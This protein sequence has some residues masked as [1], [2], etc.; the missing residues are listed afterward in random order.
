MSND[1]ITQDEINAYLN[2]SIS[3]LAELPEFVPFPAG[4]HMCVMDYEVRKLGDDPAFC[5]KL[6]GQE[7]VEL[8]DPDNDK[9]IEAG[10]E[11]EL[12]FNLNNEF[13]QGR[14][15]QLA[16]KFAIQQGLDPATTPIGVAMEPFKGATLG[17]LTT[18]RVD[19]K[20]PSKKYTQIKDIHFG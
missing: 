16:E 17:F 15:R 20:D 5:L 1:K 13:G 19:K 18:V 9:P 8:S 14:L 4:L 11:V 3:D 6:T 2:S 10:H 12:S 7:T